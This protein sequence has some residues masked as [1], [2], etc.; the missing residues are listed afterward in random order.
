MIYL[1]TSVL[2]AL[3]WA[4]ALSDIVEELVLVESELGLSQ[5]VEVELFSAL[6]RRVRMREISPE[7]ATGIVQRFQADLDSS[8]Y[9]CI[10]VEPIHYNLAREWISRFET[11][12]RTL[13]A[14]HLAIASQNNI[15]LVTADEALAASAGVLGVEFQLLR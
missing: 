2:A 9:T 13:D 3:Y 14:L 15:R 11:P 12:L 6:S 5:L 8:F 7:E 1:D 4:E 10:A